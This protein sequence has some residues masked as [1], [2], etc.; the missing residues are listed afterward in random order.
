MNVDNPEW[1]RSKS[2]L[3]YK[4]HHRVPGNF[5]SASKSRL[6]RQFLNCALC[7]QFQSITH[8]ASRWSYKNIRLITS[9]SPFNTSICPG[10]KPNFLTRLCKLLQDWANPHCH[11]DPLTLQTSTTNTGTFLGTRPELDLQAVCQELLS[12]WSAVTY[13]LCLPKSYSHSKFSSNSTS[14][15]QHISVSSRDCAFF[16]TCPNYSI[17]LGISQVWMGKKM[18]M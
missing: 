15:L 11:P 18:R 4:K 7:L 17:H 1:F 14:H 6:S 8:T 2:D 5:N 10:E 12:A 13:I 16:S 3:M 9:F